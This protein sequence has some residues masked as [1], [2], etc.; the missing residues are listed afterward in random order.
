[1]IYYY[2]HSYLKSLTKNIS[3]ASVAQAN[4]HT[5]LQKIQTCDKMDRL[6]TFFDVQETLLYVS[7][8]K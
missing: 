1:M 6:K 8:L 3:V 5:F 2:S 4:S 7:L